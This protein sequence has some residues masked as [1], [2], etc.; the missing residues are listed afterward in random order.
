MLRKPLGI[1]L[2]IE[3]RLTASALQKPKNSAASIEPI[4]LH[5]PK[6]SAASA[7]KPSPDVMFLLKLVVDS[8]VKYA[9]PKPATMPPTSTLR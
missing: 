2:L 1:G 6:I 9:P 5:R 8:S 3:P 4:G 7:T